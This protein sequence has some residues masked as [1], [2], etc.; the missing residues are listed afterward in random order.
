VIGIPDY[1]DVQ[2]VADWIELRIL[3]EGEGTSKTAL[4]SHLESI[5]GEEPADSFMGFVWDELHYRHSILLQPHYSMT[6]Q[7]VEPIMSLA[8]WPFYVAC[9]ILSLHG[10]SEGD[11]TITKLFERLSC[12]AVRN[13]LQGNAIVVG[14]PRGQHQGRNRKRKVQEIA[15]L[16][17]ERFIEEP[18]VRYND[19]GVD[20]IGWS[21][22]ADKR[23]GQV[24][25]LMQSA[26][27][28]NWNEKPPV[29]LEAWCEYIHWAS[30]PI[31][32]FAV[33]CVVIRTHWHDKSMD[34]GLLFD[35]I[36]I[37]NLLTAGSQVDANLSFE[38]S[39]WIRN[40]LPELAT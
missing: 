38:L 32:A 11:R 20:V 6:D 29:P 25:I 8:V 36:R 13:Y 40:T 3:V 16:V 30:R 5:G 33:P 21:P 15:Q 24:V 2:Q 27:G 19:R 4:S 18:S 9:L 14:W 37:A 12:Q 39:N 28:H 23:S 26:A 34:K 17:D 1:N 31:R 35:R 10:C 22:F 7:I